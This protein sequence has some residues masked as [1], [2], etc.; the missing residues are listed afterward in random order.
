MKNYYRILGLDPSCGLED[1][2]RAFRRLAKKYHP[3]VGGGA[4]P[5]DFLRIKEAYDTLSDRRRRREYDL[6]MKYGM[7][8][9]AC[10]VRPMRTRPEPVQDL[11]DDIVDAVRDSFG[12][13]R[14]GTLEA[15]VVLT[16]REAQDGCIFPLAIPVKRTCPACFGFGSRFF[17]DCPFCGGE[18][19]I[20]V[21]KY[22][23]V[24]IRPGAFTGQLYELNLGSAY[25]KLYITVR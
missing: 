6:R 4:I 14:Q 11:F 13:P 12:F 18:G 5:E 25:V 9:P 20:T 2:K 3:D 24:K 17:S 1:L 15:E 23:R 22:V 21:K 19:K 7:V 10:E 8:P 16:Q